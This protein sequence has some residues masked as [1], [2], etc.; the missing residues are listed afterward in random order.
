MAI[1]KAESG[2]ARFICSAILLVCCTQLVLAKSKL[3]PELQSMNQSSDVI[4]QFTTPVT[5]GLKNSVT[6]NGGKVK[7]TFAFINAALY[8]LPAAAIKALEHNPNV[9]YVSPDRV[10]GSSWLDNARPAVNA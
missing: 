3:S 9:R 8:N 4:V 1:T 10:L 7:Q 5:D 2:T 6:Q